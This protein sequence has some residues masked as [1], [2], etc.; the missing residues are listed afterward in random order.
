MDKKL[1]GLITVFF[2]VFGVFMTFLLFGRNAPVSIRAN[3]NIQKCDNSFIFANDVSL[4]I[5]STATFV[6]YVRNSEGTGLPKVPVTCATT[7][8]TISSSNE[9]ITANSGSATF[10]LTSDTAGIATISCSTP[11][12]S[13]F[14]KN[15]T[16]QFR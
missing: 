11:S 3:A 2:L 9:S 7:L 5:G 1:V 8:G 12:C 6:A 10:T 4:A 15:V 13:S 14:A 16:I